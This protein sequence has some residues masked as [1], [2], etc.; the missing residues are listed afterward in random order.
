[1]SDKHLTVYLNDHLAGAVTAIELLQSI[2]KAHGG[3]PLAR[4]VAGLR[5][6]IL[7]DRR[8]LEGIIKRLA[9]SVS[10]PRKIVGWFAEKAAEIKL[11]MDDPAGGPLR[12]LESL[13]IVAVGI[14][15]KRALWR[16][17]AS[18]AEHT[19]VLRETD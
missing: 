2:E 8:E 14:D 11:R 9:G 19:P 1:M 3:T 15:G 6:E 10:T 7:A 17:L 13:E 5:A 4:S 12:L 18:V 16:S